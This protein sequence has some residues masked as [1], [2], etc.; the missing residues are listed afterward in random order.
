[1]DPSLASSGNP[2]QISVCI[3]IGLLCTQSDPRLRPDMRRVVVMLSRK[4]GTLEEPTRPGYPG[5]RYRRSHKSHALTSSTGTSGDSNFNS[6]SSQTKTN[7]ASA[8]TTTS[9]MTNPR[10]DP[11]G[12]RPMQDYT[13]S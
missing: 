6:F 12:K 13:D 10:S 1:M 4:P 3:Q 5:S 11:K 2:D 8:T 9:A 7:S